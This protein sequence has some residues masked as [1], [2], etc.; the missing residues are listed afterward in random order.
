MVPWLVNRR[1]WP[2]PTTPSSLRHLCGPRFSAF[3]FPSCY[4]LSLFCKKSEKTNSLFSNSSALPKKECFSNSFPVKS[5]RTLL[6]N[7]RGA[8]LPSAIISPF[9]TL[10]NTHRSELAANSRRIRI[11]AKHTPNHFRIRSSKTQDLKLFRIRTYE[12]TRGRGPYRQPDTRRR[13]AA[14]SDESRGTRSSLLYVATS[15]LQIFTQLHSF[16]YGTRLIRYPDFTPV[17][18]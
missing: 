16:E 6:Q 8:T 18:T 9:S 3:R 2:F 1:R 5:F 13:R 17:T 11:S 12:K 15:L 14:Q 4:T 10:W 7:T